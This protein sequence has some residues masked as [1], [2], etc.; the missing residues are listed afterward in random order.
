MRRR[1]PIYHHSELDEALV[2][3]I[4]DVKNGG[5]VLLDVR[6]EVELERELRIVD[7]T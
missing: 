4:D 1:G 3:T 2:R 6:V 5:R 7:E